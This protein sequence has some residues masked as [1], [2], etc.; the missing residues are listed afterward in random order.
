MLDES[1]RVK[2]RA[3]TASNELGRQV[4]AVVHGEQAPS[5]L[6]NDLAGCGSQGGVGGVEAIVVAARTICDVPRSG[7]VV[8]DLL[9]GAVFHS[10]LAVVEVNM[11]RQDKVD[12]V[13]QK[14]RLEGSLAVSATRLATHV[15]WTVAS[16]DDPGGLL[17][18]DGG[19]IPL[20]PL[21]L[22]AIGRKGAGVLI[23][24]AAWEIRCIGKVSFRIE[25]HVMNHPVIEGV[26]EVF[27]SSRLG[28]R[29]AIYGKY[30]YADKGCTTYFQ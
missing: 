10:G 20:Q 13:F 12:T 18:V 4:R 6:D 21:Q 27:K 25:L 11:A 7:R 2:H 23:G 26:P 5:V 9:G 15:P 3:I 24:R 14:E 16:S 29:H 30:A 28:R 22:G 8:C 1:G 19:E 17:A